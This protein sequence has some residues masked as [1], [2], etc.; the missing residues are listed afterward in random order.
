M[1]AIPLQTILNSALDPGEQRPVGLVVKDMAVISGS[2]Y[3]PGSFL[4]LLFVRLRTFRK[5]LIEFKLGSYRAY[6]NLERDISTF[7]QL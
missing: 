6:P 2:Q 7:V 1:V 5:I 3:S 4:L